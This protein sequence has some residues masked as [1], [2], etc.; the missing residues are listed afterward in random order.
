MNIFV[1]VERAKVDR[2]KMGYWELGS[3]KLP[4]YLSSLV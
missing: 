3:H 1:Y 2:E 4:L